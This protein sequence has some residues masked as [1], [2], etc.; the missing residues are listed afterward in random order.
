MN[1][2]KIQIIL[3]VSIFLYAGNIFATEVKDSLEETKKDIIQWEY[4]LTHTER[5]RVDIDTSMDFFYLYEP[6]GSIAD[7]LVNAAEYGSP[8]FSILFQPKT[9]PFCIGAYNSSVQHAEELPDYTAQ[10]PYS[11][12]FYSQGLN[13]EQSAR[14]SHIQNVNKYF[15]LGFNLNFYKTIGEWDNQGLKGQHIT[16]WITYYG[17]RFST[18]FKYAYNH[19]NRQ[20]NGGIAV[21]SLLN[22]EKLLRMKFPNASSDLRFQTAEFVQKWNLGRRAKEDSASLD[23][24]RYKNAFGYKLNYYSTKRSYTDKYPDTTFYTNVL[25]DSLA[26]NDSLF[27]KHVEAIV[28]VEFQRKIKDI[29]FVA[30]FGIGSEYCATIFRDYNY[31]IPEYFDNSQFYEGMFDVSMPKEFFIEHKHRF[32][33]SGE[34]AINWES[35]TGIKKT[36]NFSNEE[37]LEVNVSHEYSNSYL[38][39]S[40]N[41]FESNHYSFHTELDAEKKNEFYCNVSSSWG[42]LEAETHFYLMKNYVFFDANGGVNQSDESGNAFTLKL[43]KTS[44]FWH[45]LMKNGLIYQNI[46]VGVQDYPTWA[47]YNSLAFQGAF[48]KKLIHFGIGAELLYYPSYNAPTYDPVL[49]TFLPQSENEYGGFPIVNVFAT[50]KYK[51]IRLYVKYTSLYAL[52]KEQNYV[53]AGYPQTNGTLSFGLSWLLY[54]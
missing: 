5:Y 50:I 15:N 19:I 23:L 34:N 49:G 26:T 48:L 13:S 1:R 7:Y 21:D 45:I 41:D 40:W 12:L 3:L 22:Y 27:D 25:Y 14:F 8:A 10:R 18:T 4:N 37:N 52:L 6:N 35:Y 44:R 32:Y 42:D 17:P 47:T 33:F 11:N 46:A 9:D 39:E 29:N 54:N 51:P 16:P 38:E 30:N 43:Q 24:L 2:L 53:I 28:F 31:S 36:F 20:E